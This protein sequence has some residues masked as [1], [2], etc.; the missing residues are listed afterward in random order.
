MQGEEKQKH[1]AKIDSDGEGS[2]ERKRKAI[3]L[4]PIA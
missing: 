1:V 2:A 3:K 4:L